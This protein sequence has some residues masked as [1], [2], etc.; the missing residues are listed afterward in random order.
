MVAPLAG[1]VIRQR[2]AIG[3]VARGE[4]VAEVGF[5][6]IETHHHGPWVESAEHSQQGANEPVRGMNGRAIHGPDPVG[7]AAK[8]GEQQIV[9]VDDKGRVAGGGWERHTR[10]N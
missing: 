8:A 5:F 4:N 2:Q 9:A 7:H 1:L 10:A 6:G 3:L